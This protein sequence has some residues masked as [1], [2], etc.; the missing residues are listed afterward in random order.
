MSHLPLCWS[1]TSPLPKL[2][3]CQESPER[4]LSVVVVELLDLLGAEGSSAG[5]EIGSGWVA[6]WSSEDDLVANCKE[7]D[8]EETEC[9]LEEVLS[10]ESKTALEVKLV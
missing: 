3:I 9:V 4:R 1:T 2:D 5:D 7:D 8:D 6:P 10:G